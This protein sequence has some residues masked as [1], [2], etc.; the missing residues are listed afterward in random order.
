[1]RRSAYNHQRLHPPSNSYSTPTSCQHLRLRRKPKTRRALSLIK[2]SINAL[3]EDIAENRHTNAI[4][5]LDS[6]VAG[7]AA[8]RSKVDVATRNDESPTTDDDAEVGQ[9]GAARENVS[10]VVAA[11]RGTADFGVVSFDVGVGNEQESGAG[12]GDGGADVAAGGELPEA[13]GA[14]DGDVGDGAGVLGAVDVAEV[15]S[16]RGA[17]LEVDGEELL[18]ERRLHGIEEGGLPS[19]SDGVDGAESEAEE[20]V[21]VGVFGELGGD[22]SGGFDGLRG[23]GD[24]TH[25]DLVSVDIATG[26]G[27]VLVGD[28]PGSARDL[29][30]RCRRVVLGVA[31]GLAG[32]G[33]S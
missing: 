21:V 4:V 23:C 28:L 31:C 32:G 15:V 26:S 6:T 24:G 7:A 14:V 22:C 2:D 10:A 8:R 17:L 9:S 29:P 5:R 11:V 27:A 33:L 12:V 16:A 1:V 18:L 25:D 3:Q 19:R 20:A 13:T 30:A